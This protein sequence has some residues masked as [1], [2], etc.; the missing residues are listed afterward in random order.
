[1]KKMLFLVAAVL[2]SAPTATFAQKTT[3]T[4]V[5]REKTYQT[6]SRDL[7][8]WYQGEL[9]FGYGLGGK[10]KYKGESEDAKFSRA[11]IE[12]IHGVRV[13][14]YAFAGMG[15]GFQ[16][17]Y[18]SKN[19]VAFDDGGV[20]MIPIF[21]DLKGYYP[22]SEK[23]APYVAIDLGYGLPVV[24]ASDPDDPDE[25]LKGGFYASYGIGLNYKKLNF[26]LGWQHQGF[27]Y[28]DEGEKG[29]NFSINSFYVKI[30]V[31]F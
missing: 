8:I 27:H 30:G 26:G 17:A 14:Q 29:D 6:S 13:T 9:N 2:L 24:G 11:F 21:L 31:K 22:V 3:V 23:F 16:Y 4:R 15:V 12:T 28:E 19:L 18:D 7:N 1:M 10:L 25:K 20:G 5:N